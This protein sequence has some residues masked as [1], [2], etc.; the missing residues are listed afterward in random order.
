MENYFDKQAKELYNKASEIINTHSM[1][2]ANRANEK[3][4]IDIPQDFKY[5][6]FSLVD[7]VNLSLMEEEDNFYGYFLFQMSREIRFDISSPTGVNFKGA[8]YIIYFNPIIFLTLDIK[9]METTIK[10]QIHHILS[11][12]LMR[13]KE[14]KGKYSTLAINM[15]MDIVVNKFL[16]NL[17]PY[18]TTLEWVNL[19]YSLKLEPYEPFEYYVE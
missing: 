17:P 12:H 1:L 7:K 19:K 16:N 5:E 6:F 4:D 18:A 2:K 10:H 8:K 14:L 11:M 3:F 13:A 15:A 9:Q